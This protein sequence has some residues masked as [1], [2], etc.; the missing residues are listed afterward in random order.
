M[1]G[2]Q[3]RDSCGSSRTGETHRRLRRGGSP[4]ARGKRASGEIN[5]TVLLGK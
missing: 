5:L 1:I 2:A 3:V 4:P